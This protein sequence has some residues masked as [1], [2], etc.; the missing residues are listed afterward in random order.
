VIHRTLALAAALFAAASSLTACTNASCEP[1]AG[2]PGACNNFVGYTWNGTRCAAQ[3]GCLC[4]ANGCPGVY[5]DLASCQNDHQ[6]CV[7][8]SASDAPAAE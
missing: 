8:D 5:P 3:N 6:V 2:N 7:M 1:Y 4:E